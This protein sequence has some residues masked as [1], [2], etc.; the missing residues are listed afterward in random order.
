MKNLKINAL[1]MFLLVMLVSSIGASAQNERGEREFRGKRARMEQRGPRGPM[2]PDLTEEQQE[3]IK[4]IRLETQKQKLPLQNELREKKARMSTLTTAENP[5]MKAINKLIDEMGAIKVK[6]EKIQ[7][8]QHQEVRKQLTED[9]R[10]VF[11]SHAGQRWKKR[12]KGEHRRNRE[13]SG[14]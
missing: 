4:A 1:W 5:D 9:Q 3:K 10:V 11:D 14:R 7:A 13:R 12:M 6:M 8:A 2:I